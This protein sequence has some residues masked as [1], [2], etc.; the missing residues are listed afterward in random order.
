V[1]LD[2]LRTQDITVDALITIGS[3]LGIDPGWRRTPI[4]PA[5]FTGIEI[6][7]WL[8]VV[9]TR[10]PIVWGRGVSEHYPQALDAYI[11]TGLLPFGPGG[12]H[13]PATY[14]GSALV[15]QVLASLAAFGAQNRIARS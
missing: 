13:D 12:A 14:L 1:A 9:N 5:E 3:P 15:G 10:D 6:G 11:T 7:T 2:A 4:D 8:N